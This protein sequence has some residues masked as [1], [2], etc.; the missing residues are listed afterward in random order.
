LPGLKEYEAAIRETIGV[1]L[2]SRLTRDQALDMASCTSVH[3][4]ISP[5]F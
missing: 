5:Y 3:R 2:Q 4:D 1:R